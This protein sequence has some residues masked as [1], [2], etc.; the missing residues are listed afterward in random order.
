M[1]PSALPSPGVVRIIG[2]PGKVELNE[3]R[4]VV[5][6]ATGF[7]ELV[8]V[9]VAL[10]ER[11]EMGIIMVDQLVEKIK[12]GVR[13][14]HRAVATC[15]WGVWID[16]TDAWD[17]GTGHEIGVESAIWKDGNSD[18]G[19]EQAG[20]DKYPEAGHDQRLERDG[21]PC[22]EN[23]LVLVEVVPCAVLVYLNKNQNKK[24]VDRADTV[25]AACRP[26]V[27]RKV[28]MRCSRLFSP[29]RIRSITDRITDR[30]GFS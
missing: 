14:E 9:P 19:E 22:R 16:E 18:F 8:G 17:G 24:K 5:N 7:I 1:L 6:G 4:E 29:D 11:S 12:G 10:F 28:R 21:G 26:C 25:T 13:R 15:D 20:E 27:S 23:Y 30:A 2:P 3:G